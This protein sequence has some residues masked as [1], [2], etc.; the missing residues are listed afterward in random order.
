MHPFAY[1]HVGGYHLFVMA[2]FSSLKL[3]TAAIAM[4]E[5]LWL[6]KRKNKCVKSSENLNTL[7]ILLKIEFLKIG[8]Y[9]I[10]LIFL[11]YFCLLIIFNLN[12][13]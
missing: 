7:S 8:V 1:N 13:N 3:T 10:E 6:D 12:N 11:I 5:N 4:L 9:S 2:H